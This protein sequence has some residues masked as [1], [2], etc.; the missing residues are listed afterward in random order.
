MKYPNSLEKLIKCFEVFPGIGPKTAERLALFTVTKMTK[1]NA[2]S[3]ALAIEEAIRVLGKCNICGSIS[4]MDVCDICQ[5]NTRDATLMI[6]ENSKDVISFEKTEIFHGRY[7]VLGGLISPLSGV[8]PSDVRLANLR[9]RVEKEKIQ[10]I[11]VALSSTVS[12]EMT[13]LYIQKMFEDQ[14]IPVYKIGYGLP[15]GADIEY[16]DEIT[17]RKALEG[18]RKI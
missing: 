14:A 9:E 10:E 2:L 7:H 11:I 3:L 8:G 12:G 5:D 13:S 18:K 16:A 4:E 15:V 6:V 17:L 1:E